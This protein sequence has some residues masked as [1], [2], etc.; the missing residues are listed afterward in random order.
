MLI[1]PIGDCQLATLQELDLPD[2]FS[3]AYV[4]E[5]N[6]LELIEIIQEAFT[7]F[8]HIVPTKTWKM[9]KTV[10]IIPRV[11]LVWTNTPSERGN[12][13]KCFHA[14]VHSLHII[15]YICVY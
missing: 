4:R 2:K 8:G 6:C 12:H 1:G 7:Q 13:H 11:Q 3:C 10:R 9:Q 15:V 5:H 14:C